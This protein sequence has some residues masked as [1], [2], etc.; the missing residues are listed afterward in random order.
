MKIRNCKLKIGRGFTLIELLIVMAIIGIL[1]AL[2]LVSYG[3]AQKQAR[4]TQRK[5]D[6][7]QL[8]N[9]LENYAAAMGSVYPVATTVTALCTALTPSGYISACVSDPV[10]TMSYNCRVDATKYTLWASLESAAAGT[11]WEVCSNG[12]SGKTTTAPTSTTCTIP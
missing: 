3:A 7:A 8:R 6:L 4:D 5:S 1:V 12:R 11:F 2:A 10:A 9:G